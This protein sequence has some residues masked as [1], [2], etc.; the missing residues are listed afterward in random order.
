M[1]I[2]LF[3]EVNCVTI[4]VLKALYIDLDIYSNNGLFNETGRYSKAKAEND[5][6]FAVVTAS[7]KSG[8]YRYG[9]DRKKNA[10]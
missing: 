9:L 7:I 2:A 8:I 4:H 1:I 6:Q 5:L 10:L 3:Y